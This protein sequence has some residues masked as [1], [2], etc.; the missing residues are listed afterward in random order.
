MVFAG[1]T[2]A[3]SNSAL[4]VV[5]TSH[6]PAY[7]LPPAG[8]VTGVLLPSPRRTVCEFKGVAHYWTISVA[9]RSSSDAA[10]SYPDPA[11]G[12]EA[13]RDHIAFYAGRVDTCYVGDERARPQEGDFYGGWITSRVTGP[14]KGGSGSAGW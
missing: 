10:W 8:V 7:Y 6:P 13:L 12:Y 11:P 4:R 3:D 9:G 1:I 5:E 14:F 2:V